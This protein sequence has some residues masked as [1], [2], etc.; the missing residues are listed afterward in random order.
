MKI[1]NKINIEVVNTIG[2]TI[3]HPTTDMIFAKVDNSIFW[4]TRSDIETRIDTLTYNRIYNR[5]R[6]VVHSQVWYQVSY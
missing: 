5:V 4:R 1:G 3:Y 2:N 6:I